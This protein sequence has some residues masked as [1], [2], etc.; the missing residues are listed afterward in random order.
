MTS[1]E[2]NITR[3]LVVDDE[4]MARDILRRYIEKIPTL[5]LIGECSNAIDALVFFTK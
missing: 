2:K 1:A 3:C 4:P 5:Q